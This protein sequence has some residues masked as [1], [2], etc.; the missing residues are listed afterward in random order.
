MGVS[1]QL[2][3]D[4]AVLEEAEITLEAKRQ[5][6]L[7][8]RAVVHKRRYIRFRGVGALHVTARGS[9]VHRSGRGARCRKPH[10]YD[11]AGG[12]GPEMTSPA[13]DGECADSPR[14]EP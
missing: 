12:A 13:I 11:A 1:C 6:S 3:K 5:G 7:V 10:L 2:M 9:D 8:H 4:D 14:P